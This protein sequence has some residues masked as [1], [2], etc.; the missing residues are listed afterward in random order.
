MTRS[1]R[2]IVDDPSVRQPAPAHNRPRTGA[3]HRPHALQR[4]QRPEPEPA[5]CARRRGG[6]GRGEGDPMMRA[7]AIASTAEE[8]PPGGMHRQEACTAMRH[9]PPPPQCPARWGARVISRRAH[10]CD[11][12][13]RRRQV[14]KAAAERQAKAAAAVCDDLEPV[15]HHDRCGL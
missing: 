3:A 15:R 8:L 5:Q 6:C 13:R 9:A 1:R 10:V 11:I 7:T 12:S 14:A 2:A 4:L